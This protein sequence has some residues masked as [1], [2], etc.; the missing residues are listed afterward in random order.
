MTLSRLKNSRMAYLRI[1]RLHATHKKTRQQQVCRHRRGRQGPGGKLADIRRSVEHPA[2]Q[3]QPTSDRFVVE[4]LVGKRGAVQLG[5]VCAV[6]QD[7][8]NTGHAQEQRHEGQGGRLVL[9]EEFLGPDEAP[10]DPHGDDDDAEAGDPPA[11][12]Q[13]RLV[14]AEQVRPRGIRVQSHGGGRVGAPGTPRPPSSSAEETSGETRCDPYSNSSSSSKAMSGWFIWCC[15]TGSSQVFFGPAGVMTSD[16]WCLFVGFS[17]AGNNPR[18]LS[19]G[20]THN[21]IVTK[22]ILRHVKRP[23]SSTSGLGK[24]FRRR[25]EA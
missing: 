14:L 12:Q 5:V 19:A 20:C 8:L 4:V 7:D 11:H 22:P 25:R 6:D 18:G 21:R 24:G 15:S 3:H 13:G 23:R 16:W 10:N 9:S 2:Q 17:S 1:H